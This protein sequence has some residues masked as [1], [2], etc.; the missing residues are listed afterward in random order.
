MSNLDT[1]HSISNLNLI[2]RVE[3]S[4]CSRQ[5]MAK[6]MVDQFTKITVDKVVECHILT[7]IEKKTC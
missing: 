7:T 4:Q 5:K 2:Y 6:L 3:F 1:Q